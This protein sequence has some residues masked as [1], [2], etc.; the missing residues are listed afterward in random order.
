MLIVDMLRSIG[1]GNSFYG[2]EISFH[3]ENTT[4]NLP[5]VEREEELPNKRGNGNYYCK[6]NMMQE[7]KEQKETPSFF[8]VKMVCTL[9][10]NNA[11][12][13]VHVSI[14]Q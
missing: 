9:S 7:P 11:R 3:A 4:E 12:L 14:M 1:I 10:V 2:L 8:Q 13:I 6:Q 5:E